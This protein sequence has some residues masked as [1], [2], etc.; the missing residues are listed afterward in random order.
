ME[1]RKREFRRFCYDDYRLKGNK[2]FAVKTQPDYDTILNI[3]RLRFWNRRT[4]FCV[5][6]LTILS[7]LALAFN[8]IIGGIFLASIVIIILLLWFSLPIIVKNKFKK[9]T[10][11]KNI[12]TIYTFNKNKT[13]NIETMRNNIVISKL[14]LTQTDIIKIKETKDF[15][16]IFVSKHQAYYIN[17][18]LL[19]SLQ[20]EYIKSYHI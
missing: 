7:L 2:M 18:K 9:N 16:L 6:C 1:K 20:K 3:T 19:S 12:M 13:L 4:I 10:Y 11:G 14:Y 5:I 8:I 17:K 15:L